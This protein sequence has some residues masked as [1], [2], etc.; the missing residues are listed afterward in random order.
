MGS[1]GYIVGRARKISQ[2]T[3]NAARVDPAVFDE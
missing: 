3:R 2:T 1:T